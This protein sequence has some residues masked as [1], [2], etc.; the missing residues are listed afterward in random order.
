MIGHLNRQARASV[1]FKQKRP[2]FGIDNDVD[3]Q[4]P[5][6]DLAATRRD[7]SRISI[8]CGTTRPTS[9]MRVSG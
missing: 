4:I 8:Q 7:M 9:G 1:R 5:Q 2:T 3:S 6:A